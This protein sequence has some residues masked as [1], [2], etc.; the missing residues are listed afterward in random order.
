M[1]AIKMPR[2]INKRP[3][4]RNNHHVE[5]ISGAYR[6]KN[7]TFLNIASPPISSSECVNGPA[8]H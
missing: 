1:T 8:Y 6:S 3:S 5:P 2:P 4:N 7:V